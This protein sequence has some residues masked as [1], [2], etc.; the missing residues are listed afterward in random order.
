MRAVALVWTCV[1][2]ERGTRLATILAALVVAGALVSIILTHRRWRR[3]WLSVLIDQRLSEARRNAVP[4]RHAVS[5]GWRSRASALWLGALERWDRAYVYFRDRFCRDVTNLQFPSRAAF[6]I[7]LVIIAAFFVAPRLPSL[8]A[9]FHLAF[10]G[11]RHDLTDNLANGG[12]GLGRRIS[13]VFTGLEVVIVALIVFV[14]ESVRNDADYDRKRD[15]VQR[16]WLW[17][18]G[19]AVTLIPFGFLWSGARGLTVVLE[20]IVAAVTLVAFSGVIRA[21]IDPTDRAKDRLKFLR[22]RVHDMISDSVRE[23]IGNSLL[24]ERIGVGKQID[25]LHYTFSRAWIEGEAKDYFFIDAPAEGRLEDIHLDE[26]QKLSER[27]DSHARENLG[28]ALRE[29]GAERRAAMGDG[30]PLEVRDDKKPKFRKAYLLK[31]YRE[32]IPPDSI[33]YGKQ[34]SLLA[35]PGAFGK[36]PEFLAHI[37]AAIPR[38]FR[39]T[40]NESPSVAVRRE[41]QGTKDQLTQAI[42]DHALGAIDELTQ[43]YL[44]VAE[45]FL[46]V[47]VE[48][49]GGYTAEQA[50]KERGNFFEGWTEIRWLQRDLRELIVIAAEAGNTDVL[51]TIAF[52]PFAAAMRA[53]QAR[54]HF[55]FQTFYQFAILLYVLG[56]DNVGTSRLRDWMTDRCWRWPKEIADLYIAPELNNRSS[57]ADDLEQVR[58]FA[59]YSLRIFQDLLK[60][61]ADR[62]DIAAFRI[63]ARELHELYRWVREA[64]DQPSVSG[65]RRQAEQSDDD[66][67]RAALREELRRQEKRNEIS[68]A[69]KMAIDEIFMA[70]A[71]RVLAWRLEAPEDGEVVRML[72]VIAA[73]MPDS[74]ERT[75]EVFAEASTG[76]GSDAWGWDQWDLVADGKAHYVD[77][78]TRLNQAFVWRAL[79]LLAKLRPTPSPPMKFPISHSL[80]EMARPENGSGLMATLA[81]VADEETAWEQV[82]SAEARSHVD[83]L[84]ELL[85]DVRRE[86]LAQLEARTR[87]AQL[88]P[89]KVKEFRND[90]RQHL[91]D[92]GCLRPIFVAKN[93]LEQRLDEHPG[94]RVPFLGIN[95]IDTKDAFIAQEHT[96]YVGGGRNYGQGMAQGEDKA[97]FEALISGAQAQQPI[98]SGAVAAA[99]GEAAA[100][101]REPIILHSLAFPGPIEEIHGSSDFTPE[102]DLKTP[103]AW[104]GFKGFEGVFRVGGRQVPVFHVFAPDTKLQNRIVIADMRKF[105]RW[106]QYAPD[107]S[108]E[109]RADVFDMLLIRVTDLNEDEAK[110]EE[111]ISQNPLWLKAH[112]NPDAYLRGRVVVKVQEKFNIDILDPAAGVCLVLAWAAGADG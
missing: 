103:S 17:P 7:L 31:R 109:E 80:S 38:I 89:D 92:G 11:W 66:M 18:L 84:R 43:V 106:R 19:V 82:L 13:G 8:T 50:Q 72:D 77:R 3:G 33:F 15:L 105:A 75:A 45:E 16:S 95:Q 86:E 63:V 34:R 35:L 111:I 74:L 73:L 51:G 79:E 110:R 59:I 44:Q 49:G 54:D 107:E 42:R 30:I 2:G 25:A 27:L 57:T 1:A 64:E 100:A 37:R 26:L 102:Y 5:M 83:E 108:V 40:K 94:A 81:A 24:Y 85:A 29:A 68:A 62:R 87:D 98:A 67:R 48:L 99:T 47:L 61:M 56:Q 12:S 28:F 32:E 101:L 36:D 88:D 97:A 22:G 78:H 112:N 90:L 58:G 41:M 9:I 46:T 52:L 21:L 104:R 60:E 39:F 71:G 14:A 6:I 91:G 55:L 10:K 69:L 4:K 23:R 70:L 20:L 93:A 65:L 53:V 76:H 96:S